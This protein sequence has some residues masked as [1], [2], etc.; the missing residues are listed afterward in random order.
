M[1][2]GVRARIDRSALKHNLERARSA[3]PNS[4]VMAVVKADGYGHG[5]VE[6]AGSL[7][8]ADAF[9]VESTDE[10]V[11]LRDAGIRQGI[12]LLTGFH[13]FR[14]LDA[15]AHRHLWPVIHADWQVA[16]LARQSASIVVGVWVKIDS[17]MHRVGFAP[18]EAPAVLQVL[19]R[20]PNVR[21]EGL[22]SHLANADDLADSTTRSQCRSFLDVARVYSYPLSLA[23][24]AGVL[25]WPGTHLDWVRPGMMLYGCSPIQGRDEATLGLWPAMTLESRIVAIRTVAAG[26]A[27]GYG[28]TWRCDKATRVGVVTC[29]Y[30]DGYPR[31]AP[32]G[33]PVWMNGRPSRILGRVSM[34]LISVDLSPPVDAGIGDWVEL[35]G[36]NVT[37][38]SVAKR[39]GTIPYELVTGVTAR[40]PRVH[41]TGAS[42]Q[43]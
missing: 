8:D 26:E 23:N 14:E 18:A 15:I 11:R 3:A 41:E 9:A 40:V 19:E 20:L 13:D 12:T 43:A 33:T 16:A 10:G 36:A 37:A 5:L 27:I 22:M 35:W 38:S 4:R 21:I 25:A 29:G 31:H 7:E 6:V 32:S 42:G 2:R 34:D 30:A 17:G 1:T 24:S 39:A 28:G